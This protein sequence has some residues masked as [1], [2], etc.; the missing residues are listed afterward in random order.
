[1]NTS[2]TLL[3]VLHPQ[4]ILK[5]EK[6]PALFIKYLITLDYR[7]N[8]VLKVVSYMLSLF[9]AC[10]L[11][12]LSLNDMMSI[13]FCLDIKKLFLYLSSHLRIH[14]IIVNLLSLSDWQ[15]RD[16][17]IKHDLLFLVL[18]EG[19]VFYSFSINR[20]DKFYIRF[21]LPTVNK[22]LFHFVVLWE[23]KHR[24][25]KKIEFLVMLQLF[26]VENCIFLGRRYRKC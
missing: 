24:K 21:D 12:L 11:F 26:S 22:N 15:K 14:K 25:I 17:L 4:N 23:K 19:I 18:L 6:K 3:P 20:N 2:E 10:L 9:Y 1:M 5:R 8:Y 7:Y 16:P 13:F